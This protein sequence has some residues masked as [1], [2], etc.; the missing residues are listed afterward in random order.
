MF[1]LFEA[2]L[3]SKLGWEKPFEQLDAHLRWHAKPE[4]ATTIHDYKLAINV[5]KHG[6]G[7]SHK[8]LLGRASTLEFKVREVHDAFF[9]EGDV[10][11]VDILIDVDDAF[12]R[13]CAALI[14]EARTI[15]SETEQIWL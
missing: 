13:R 5:L 6:E 15:I 11:E 9:E 2:L 7:W 12:V 10:S 1:S 3:Q 4:L 8:E 14:D